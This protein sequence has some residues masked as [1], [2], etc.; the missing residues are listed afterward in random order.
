[1]LPK[2]RATKRVKSLIACGRW[3]EQIVGALILE[4]DRLNQAIEA[5]QG[6]IKTRGRPPK[7]VAGTQGDIPKKRKPMGAHPPEDASPLGK[8]E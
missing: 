1:M 7:A 8:A 2:S 5:L 6:P 4:R 3:I